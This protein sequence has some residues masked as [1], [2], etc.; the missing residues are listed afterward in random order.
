LASTDKQYRAGRDVS[1]SGAISRK[2]L[3]VWKNRGPQI[4]NLIRNRDKEE[5]GIKDIHK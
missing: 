5:I 4:R 1:Y 3:L 2:E